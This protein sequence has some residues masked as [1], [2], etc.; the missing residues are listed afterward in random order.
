MH[1]QTVALPVHY[2]TLCESS[3]LYDPGQ[4]Y[5]THVR[6]LQMSEEPDVHYSFEP[7]CPLSR[8]CVFPHTSE[9]RLGGKEGLRLW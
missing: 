4:Q 9:E 6:D 5:A 3:K 8:Q 7:Y 1:V 2:Q